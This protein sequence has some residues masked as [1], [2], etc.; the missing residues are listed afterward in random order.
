M[1]EIGSSIERTG[2]VVVLRLAKE[3]RVCQDGTVNEATTSDR[4]P[5]CH[6]CDHFRMRQRKWQCKAGNDHGARH[7]VAKVQKAA[8]VVC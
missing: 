7:K 5:A 2:S 3:S 1:R 4:H 6:R 8:V